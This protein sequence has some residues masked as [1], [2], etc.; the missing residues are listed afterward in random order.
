MN[1]MKI[2]AIAPWFGSKRSLAPTIIEELGPHRAY[3]EVFGGSAAVLMVKDRASHETFVDLHGGLINLA[4]VLQDLRLAEQLYHQASLTLCSSEI[5]LESQRWIEQHPEAEG[6][7]AAYHYFV[8]SW[9]GRNG[10]AGCLRTNYQPSM[11]YTPNGGS[12][13]TRWRSV[14]ESIPDWYDRLR[15]VQIYRRDAFDVIGNIYDV[16][17][18]ALYVDPPYLKATRAGGA[19]YLHEFEEADHA[20]LAEALGRFQEARV[21]LSYYDDPRLEQLYPGWTIRK[22]YRQKNL[23][24]QNQ[25]G[26]GAAWRR[27]CFC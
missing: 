12:G 21:V 16:E 3:F 8:V 27:R 13:P 9:M 15:N 24:V 11:R 5:F 4:R 17:G 26:A 25:R 2:T 7:D 20:R 19:K 22:C 18:V 14:T 10:T 23:H 6:L 1:G